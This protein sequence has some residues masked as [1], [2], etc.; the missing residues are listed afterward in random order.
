MS[1]H[2]RFG[3]KADIGARPINVCFTLKSGHHRARSPCPF[4][5]K[6]RNWV[7]SLWSMALS[8]V[9]ADKVIW[10]TAPD[11]GEVED[12]LMEWQP[13]AAALFGL[14]VNR[15]RAMLGATLLLFV[16]LP[17]TSYSQVFDGLPITEQE[18]HWFAEIRACCGLGDAFVADSFYEK[19]GKFYAVI[20]DGTDW[21]YR[22]KGAIRVGTAIE[23]PAD[24]LS[25]ANDPYYIEHPNPTHHGVV[26]LEVHIVGGRIVNSDGGPPEQAKPV[27]YFKPGGA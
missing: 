8:L 21:F 26:F 15:S 19:A 16:L 24:M 22:I 17:R 23:I 13:I 2:V 10:I 18:R 7:G 1:S 20:T 5:A 6:S 3:S 12:A 14:A 9:P 4:C 27:C 25:A 11:F